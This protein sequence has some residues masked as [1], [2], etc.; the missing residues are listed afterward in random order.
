[1]KAD[2]GRYRI[3]VERNGLKMCLGMEGKLYLMEDKKAWFRGTKEE[4]RE[5]SIRR[6]KLLEE[7]ERLYFPM[8]S[9][10]N[11]NKPRKRKVKV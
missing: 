8:V 11:M 5:E 3:Y 1:M 2:T 10:E 7:N 6:L 4:A 9:Y